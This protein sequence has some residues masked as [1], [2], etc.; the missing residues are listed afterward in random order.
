MELQRKFRVPYRN[1]LK[2]FKL[3]AIAIILTIFYH[4]LFAG[5]SRNLNSNDS[6]RRPTLMQWISHL[7]RTAAYKVEKETVCTDLR[8][9]SSFTSLTTFASLIGI[10]FTAFEDF[11]DIKNLDTRDELVLDYVRCNHLVPPVGQEEPYNLTRSTP[12]E[13]RKQIHEIF[14][15]KVSYRIEKWQV[16]LP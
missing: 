15:N 13:F 6:R 7:L 8:K 1:R 9:V 11:E 16:F 2:I 14:Q 12:S 4:V 3:I 10:V 5:R